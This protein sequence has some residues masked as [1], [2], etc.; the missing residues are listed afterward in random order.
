M[1]ATEL[2]KAHALAALAER[3]ANRPVLPRNES[4]PAGSPMFFA[5]IGCGGEIVVAEDWR[6]KPDLC[7]ECAALAA[8][9][10]ME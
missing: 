1:V 2:G 10:W 8:L 3:R 6:T 5:C 9:G 4:L 7:R